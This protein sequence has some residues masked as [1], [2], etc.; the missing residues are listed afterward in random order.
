MLLENFQQTLLQH[1]QSC[2]IIIKTTKTTEPT[3][4]EPTP[5]ETAP[6]VAEEVITGKPEG[7]VP[8]E[9]PVDEDWDKE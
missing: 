9:Q 8:E 2:K 1:Q 7:Q 6:V 3:P 4:T 5:T